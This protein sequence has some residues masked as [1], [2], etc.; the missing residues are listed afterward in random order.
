MPVCERIGSTRF[1]AD[2]TALSDI[3]SR[4]TCNTRIIF[5]P[6]MS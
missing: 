3:F 4:D 6:S 2:F 5:S 1:T